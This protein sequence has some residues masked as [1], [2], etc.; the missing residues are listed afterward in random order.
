M[1]SELE[2]IAFSKSLLSKLGTL[3]T[4]APFLIDHVCFRCDTV[5]QYQ[6]FKTALVKQYRLLSANQ[7]NKREI[8]IFEFKKPLE[9][10]AYSCALLELT[11]PKQARNDAAGFE[12][13][14][15]ICDAD[16]RK[17]IEKNSHLNF[18]TKNIDTENPEI[19]L[20]YTIGSIKIRNIGLKVILAKEKNN[21]T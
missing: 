6:T 12:H 8:S 5:L 15:L 11:A 7:V 21:E 10:E 2:A 14:E 4:D 1:I 9:I 16:L 3:H 19:R 17:L 20:N 18:N 13:I